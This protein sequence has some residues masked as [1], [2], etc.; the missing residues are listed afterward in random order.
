MVTTILSN[1]KFVI[2]IH[3]IHKS[4]HHCITSTVVEPVLGKTITSIEKL[5]TNLLATD[6]WTRAVAMEL[7]NIAQGYKETTLHEQTQFSSLT[8]IQSKTFPH[9]EKSH[10]TDHRN[11]TQTK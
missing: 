5:A 10:I 7:G 11:R 8:M 6:T 9:M 1:I 3:I 2:I 4:H